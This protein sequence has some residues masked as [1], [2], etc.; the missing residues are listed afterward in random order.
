MGDYINNLTKEEN[1]NNQH[2]HH[3]DQHLRNGIGYRDDIDTALLLEEVCTN[4]FNFLIFFSWF[5]FILLNSSLL[6][7]YIVCMRG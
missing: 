6:C 2:H 7:F 1:H 4:I 5:F 3:I